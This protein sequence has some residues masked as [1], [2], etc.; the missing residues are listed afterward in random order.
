MSKN[1][2]KNTIEV[3]IK[4]DNYEEMIEFLAENLNIIITAVIDEKHIR[5]ILDQNLEYGNRLD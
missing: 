1:I 4:V 2:F 5:R 3:H